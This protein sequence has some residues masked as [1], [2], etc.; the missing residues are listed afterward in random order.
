[1]RKNIQIILVLLVVSI[2][3]FNNVNC[4]KEKISNDSGLKDDV[5]HLIEDE[6]IMNNNKNLKDGPIKIE[7]VGDSKHLFADEDFEKK[8]VVLLHQKNQSNNTLNSSVE[9]KEEINKT[10]VT[11]RKNQSTNPNQLD[12]LNSNLTVYRE[13]NTVQLVNGSRLTNLLGE[14]DTNQCFLVLFYVPWCKFSTRLAPIYNALPK[15]FPNLDIL[16]FDVSKSIG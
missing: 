12:C 11:K 4:E 13:N 10:V 6:I 7:I 16:A 15:A 5:E 2:L 14:S 1:M 3:A 8:E 9:T